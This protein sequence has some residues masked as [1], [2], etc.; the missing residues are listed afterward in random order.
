M[1]WRRTS[2]A[3]LLGLCAVASSGSLAGV[4]LP[5]RQMTLLSCGPG[6]RIVA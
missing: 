3:A 6:E 5:S 1:S 2:L 4:T